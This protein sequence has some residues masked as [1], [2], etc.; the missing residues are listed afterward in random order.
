MQQNQHKPPLEQVRHAELTFDRGITTD[1][2][3]WQR[4]PYVLALPR[5]PK[6]LMP[7]VV[8]ALGYTGTQRWFS[9]YHS[10]AGLAVEDGMSVQLFDDPVEEDTRL[11]RFNLMVNAFPFA[12][13]FRGYNLGDGETNPEHLHFILIDRQTLSIWVLPA[14]KARRVLNERRDEQMHNEVEGQAVVALFH[15]WLD[16]QRKLI[17]ADDED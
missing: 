14:R 1:L 11:G 10:P 15:M 2:E 17:F 5:F 8:G 16:Q 12:E 3:E 6:K 13:G 7:F 9:M 4:A